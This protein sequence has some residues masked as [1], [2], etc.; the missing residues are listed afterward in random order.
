LAIQSETVMTAD[1]HA[2]ANEDRSGV[3]FTI[4]L[5]MT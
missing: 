4:L 5:C 1:I 2:I 3:T